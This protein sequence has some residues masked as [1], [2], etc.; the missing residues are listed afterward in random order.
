MASNGP[1][2]FSRYSGLP[3]SIRIRTIN[4]YLAT[5]F[6]VCGHSEA[7]FSFKLALMGAHPTLG[8]SSPEL[9]ALDVIGYDLGS[10][11]PEPAT[12][13]LMGGEWWRS[14]C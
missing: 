13:L 1:D 9:V 4:V 14:E 12:M 11:I 7:P 10:H 2:N 5:P 3:V 8:S 6:P